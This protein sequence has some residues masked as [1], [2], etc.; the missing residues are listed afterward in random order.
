[1]Y[2]LKDKQTYAKRMRRNAT[3]GEK[4]LRWWLYIVGYGFQE[5]DA[6]GFL[7]DFYSKFAGV[8]IEVDG[9]IHKRKDIKY[10]DRYKDQSRRRKKNYTLRVSNTMAVKYPAIVAGEALLTGIIYKLWRITVW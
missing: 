2:S 5:Y 9:S 4:A 3:S 8:A 10:M 7:P 6:A 1:M